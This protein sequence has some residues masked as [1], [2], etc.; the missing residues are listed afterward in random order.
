M[1]ELFLSFLGLVG[2]VIGYIT[3]HHDAMNKVKKEAN[4]KISK[5][6]AKQKERIQGI[7]NKYNAIRDRLRQANQ[8][9]D[10]TDKTGKTR[11]S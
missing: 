11:D 4:L 2:T 7:T 3:G 5:V 1:K 9:S 8:D 10:I 6:H